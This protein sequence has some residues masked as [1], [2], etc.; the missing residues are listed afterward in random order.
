MW[1]DIEPEAPAARRLAAFGATFLG[2]LTLSNVAFAGDAP[3]LAPPLVAVIVLLSAAG[4]LLIWIKSRYSRAVL[5]VAAG[6]ALLA[7][8]GSALVAMPPAWL[9]YL[10]ILLGLAGLGGAVLVA[11]GILRPS[12]HVLGSKTRPVVITTGLLLVLTAAP[13]GPGPVLA[14]IAAGALL[15]IVALLRPVE[16]D[17]QD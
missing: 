16:P 3:L 14:L 10:L 7:A 9:G 15:S 17:Q 8:A 2:L 5:W 13:V 1:T 4:G 12:L 6:F 11:V